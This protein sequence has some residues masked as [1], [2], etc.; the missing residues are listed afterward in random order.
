MG[1][2]VQHGASA[3]GSLVTQAD[4]FQWQRAAVRELAAILEAHPSLPAI[5]WTIG[6]GGALSGRINGLTAS[7]AEVHATFTAWRD[8]LRPDEPAGHLVVSESPVRHLR[9]SGRRGTVSV[10]ITANVFADEPTGDVAGSAVSSSQREVV[11]PA[12]L[13]DVICQEDG[14]RV[15]PRPRDHLAAAGSS[16]GN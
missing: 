7:A 4:R 1:E 3:S 13:L 16:W 10:R 11:R 14:T 12:R 15:L 5:T 6:P 2:H 8:A 9:A